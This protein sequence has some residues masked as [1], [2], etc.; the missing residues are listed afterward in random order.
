MLYVPNEASTEQVLDLVREW[1]DLLSQGDYTAAAAVVLPVN[2][3]KIVNPEY[4]ES[5]IKRYRSPEYYPGVID[6]QVTDWRTAQ[7]G[8]PDAQQNV[9]WYLPNSST[10]RASVSFDLPLNG[11]WSDLTA[12]LV[13]WEEE[14]SREGSVLC[15]EDVR[16]WEQVLREEASELASTSE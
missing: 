13:F 6:F 10:L 9:I 4:L 11:R 2:G 8:N 3:D 1:I 12:E 5:D 7:G 15:L 14:D 16:S